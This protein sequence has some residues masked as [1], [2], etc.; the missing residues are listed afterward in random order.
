MSVFSLSLHTHVE[1][2]WLSWPLC[3][4]CAYAKGNHCMWSFPFFSPGWEKTLCLRESIFHSL[5][6]W[7]ASH[8]QK[9]WVLS[10]SWVW[11]CSAFCFPSSL[12][13]IREKMI[14]ELS[15]RRD[16]QEFSLDLWSNLEPCCRRLQKCF[17]SVEKL[18][19][20]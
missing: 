11:E 18:F 6:F 2:G 12:S 17:F 9:Q 7:S 8:V 15:C 16:W 4:T 10:S 19:W 3:S 1:C 13:W 20:E 14:L 5:P